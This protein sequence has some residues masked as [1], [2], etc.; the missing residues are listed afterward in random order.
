[1]SA[2]DIVIV[3]H[4]NRTTSIDIVRGGAAYVAAQDAYDAAVAA[5]YTGTIIE[6]FTPVVGDF[7]TART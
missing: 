5:G 2:K 4:P 1:M 7:F 3:S 6:Y